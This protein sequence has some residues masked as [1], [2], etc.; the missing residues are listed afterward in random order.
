MLPSLLDDKVFLYE[1]ELKIKGVIEEFKHSARARDI[2]ERS[3]LPQNDGKVID[4]HDQ[5][6]RDHKLLLKL[7]QILGVMPVQRGQIGKITFSWFSIPTIYAYCFYVITTI[8]VLLV[9]Y[10]RI[11]IL[12]QKSKKFDE[13]IYSI[14]FVVFLVPHFWIPFVGWGVA[15]DVCDYKNSWGF[16]QLD[17][18][19]IT[20]KSLE[21]PHL[22]VLI[23]IISSGCLILAIIFLLTLSALLEGFTMYHTTAYIHIITMINMNCALWYINCRAIGNASKSVADSFEQDVKEY[24]AGYIVKHYRVLWLNLSEILQKLGNAYARTYSTYSLFMITNITIAIYGL[25]SEIVDHGFRFTFKETGLLVDAGYC[26]VLLYIFCDCSHNASVNIASR[27]QTTLLNMD[28]TSVDTSTIKEIELF[29][30]AIEMNPPKVSLRGYTIVNRE[31]I[32]SVS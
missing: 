21:F 3:Q 13:Y 4:E 26:M 24:C 8:L 17:Y 14:I 25:T 5:F 20:G 2:K 18:Y 27:V 31:L 12:T 15:K 28:L 9:G 10:E 1:D 19:K 22:S 11:I 29:L 32:S 6:Y 16:F 23:I 30:I 7:F